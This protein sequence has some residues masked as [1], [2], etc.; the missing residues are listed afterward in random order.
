L[1]TTTGQSVIACGLAAGTYDYTVTLTD[2]NGCSS[3]ANVTLTVNPTP[4][5]SIDPLDPICEDATVTITANGPAGVYE[6][7]GDGLT[8]TSGQIGHIQF[9]LGHIAGIKRW[10]VTNRDD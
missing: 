7:T 5:I 10:Q 4:E 9:F 1:A 3:T 8:T 2:A 6:W